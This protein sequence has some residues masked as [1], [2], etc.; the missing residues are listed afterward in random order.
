MEG[1][2]GNYKAGFT[3]VEIMIVVVIIGLLMSF[4]VP[5]VLKVFGTSKVNRFLNDVRIVTDA[6]QIYALDNGV[7]PPDAG[8]G[9]IPDG[10][11]GYLREFPWDLA[12]SI[13][14]KWD[15]KNEGGNVQGIVVTSPDVSM[16]ILKKIDGAVDDGDLTTGMF[17]MVNSDCYYTLD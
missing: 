10:M 7:Y 5:S 13:G 1:S 11:A 4:A 16:E 3:L 6:F 12:T 14:G 2:Q 9:V 8:V 15:W 17:R